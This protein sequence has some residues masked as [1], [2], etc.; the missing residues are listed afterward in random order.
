VHLLAHDVP[1]PGRGAVER[2]ELRFVGFTEE[3]SRSGDGWRH[4]SSNLEILY[5]HDRDELSSEDLAM[6][7]ALMSLDNAENPPAH[8]LEFLA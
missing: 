2:D 4:V 6:L 1:R 8:A 3:G 7:S 5:H